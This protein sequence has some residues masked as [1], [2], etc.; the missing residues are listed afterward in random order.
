M[1]STL[2]HEHIVRINDPQ[3][4]ISPWLTREQLWRGLHHT[5]VAP[6][7]VDDSIDAANVCEIAPGR[8]RREI[9]R[10]PHCLADEVELAPE[11]SLIIRADCNSSFAGSSLT[12]CIEEPAPEVLFVR[13]IY[14]VCGL[15]DVR[16]EEEDHARRSAYQASDI[17]RIRQ[18]RRFSVALH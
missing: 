11:H 8:L 18:A 4:V 10:G 2:R 14:E 13:F 12:I 1:T 16:D 5:V 3:N 17:E 15:A 6:Q 9:Y 7:V